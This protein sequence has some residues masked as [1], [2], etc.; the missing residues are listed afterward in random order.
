MPTDP[1]L[2]SRRTALQSALAAGGMA[3]L[4][5]A[6]AAAEAKPDDRRASPKRYDM[7]KSINL[8]AFPYPQRM[9]LRE[10]L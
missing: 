4:A 7:K 9:T 5:G 6:A 1:S 3:A 2:V 10:C 8:W